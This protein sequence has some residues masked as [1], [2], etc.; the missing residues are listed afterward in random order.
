MDAYPHWCAS[1]QSVCVE[2]QQL[3]HLQLQGISNPRS[4][5]FRGVGQVSY[6]S[7][8]LLF[9]YLTDC[10]RIHSAHGSVFLFLAPSQ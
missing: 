5:L 6:F 1:V 3:F 9:L 7:D 10:G 4:Q 2:K 8:D